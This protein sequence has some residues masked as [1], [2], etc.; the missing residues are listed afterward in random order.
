MN[1]A[2]EM[3]KTMTYHGLVVGL[4]H[5]PVIINRCDERFMKSGRGAFAFGAFVDEEVG[6]LSPRGRGAG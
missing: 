1:N 6:V 4:H 3:Q 2:S 5:A